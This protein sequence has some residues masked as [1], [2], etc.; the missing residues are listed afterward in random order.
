MKTLRDR[1]VLVFTAG[2]HTTASSKYRAFLLGTYLTR[3]RPDIEWNIISPSTKEM[4]ALSYSR[5]IWA[6]AKQAFQLLW[7]PR[8]HVVYIQRAIY[9]KFVFVTLLLQNVLRIRPSIFDFDDAIFMHSAFKTR[10]LC[11]TSSAVIVGSHHLE[12]YA[13]R[14]NKNVTFIPT[15]VKFSDYSNIERNTKVS[16]D[17]TIGWLGDA[18]AYLPEVRFLA[19]VLRAL[20]AR[21]PRFKLLFIGS[22]GSSEIEG[23]FN[24]FP[25]EKRTIV[26][27]IDTQSD[28]DLV[29]YFAQMDIG[30]MPL[31]DT[32]WNKGKCA[33]KAVQ[34]MASGA[35]VV[36]SPV[37][38]NSFLIDHE[39][40]GILARTQDEW[41]ASLLELIENPLLRERLGTAAREH[42]RKHYSYESHIPS[43]VALIDSLAQ[44]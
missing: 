41:V 22:Q 19:D 44:G 28:A 5:Q 43:V 26:D 7:F 33:F 34:Y 16:D 30:V 12:N 8:H 15:C 31:M 24:F 37:G 3:A 20:Y 13:R 32:E 35:A 4:S 21:N 2:D 11:K 17:V 29:P 10:W 6:A 38:Q 14:Y 9:N 18:P 1:C 36:A 40:N 42:V 27:Y 23:L 39:M 25:I